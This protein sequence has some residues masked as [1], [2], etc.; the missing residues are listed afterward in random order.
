MKTRGG[1]PGHGASEAIADNADLLVRRG[2]GIVDS[3]GNVED[4]FIDV[5]FW[6]KA[7]CG[8]HAGRIVTEF[9][10]G[11]DAVE[12]RGGDGEESVARPAISDGADVGV[13]AEDFLK[14]DEA[15]DWVAF[16][17]GNIGV[18]RVAV[19]CAESY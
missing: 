7:H 10:A 8:L 17:M 19:G 18:E 9:D 13:D 6:E 15:G 16:W 5:E 14:N 4:C 11:L 12:E 3:S 2:G 1:E